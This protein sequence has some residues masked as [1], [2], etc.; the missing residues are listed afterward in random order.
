MNS[1]RL[2]IVKRFAAKLKCAKYLTSQLECYAKIELLYYSDSSNLVKICV[3][4]NGDRELKVLIYPDQ[5]HDYQYSTKEEA[6]EILVK[7]FGFERR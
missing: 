1:K 5:I 4:S 6:V 7:E 3:I 2:E